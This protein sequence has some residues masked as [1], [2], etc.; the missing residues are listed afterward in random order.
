MQ[1][2]APFALAADI[3]AEQAI[4]G[5]ILLSG[6]VALPATV[7]EG[8]RPEDFYVEQYGQIFTLMQAMHADGESI[9][10]LTLT[11]RLRTAGALDDV[12]GRA[13]IDLLGGAV[14]EVGNLRQYARIVVRKSMWRARRKLLLEALQDHGPVDCEDETAFRTVLGRVR[15]SELHFRPLLERSPAL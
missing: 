15:E 10:T 9:D 7:E 13:A 12:G 1:H 5:A 14:P 11:D 6:T 8:V 2:D 3:E 4:L